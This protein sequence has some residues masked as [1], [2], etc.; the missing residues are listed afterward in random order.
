MHSIKICKFTR[1]KKIFYSFKH[2]ICIHLTNFFSITNSTVN[3]RQRYIFSRTRPISYLKWFSTCIW[4]SPA[5]GQSS[6]APSSRARPCC[7]PFWNL[8]KLHLTL[9]VVAFVVVVAQF[10]GH[11]LIR[12]QLRSFRNLAP[13]KF[14]QLSLASGWASIFRTHMCH[15]AIPN[16]IPSWQIVIV[17]GGPHLQAI[18]LVFSLHHLTRAFFFHFRP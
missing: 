15:I 7:C 11:I 6:P 4:S 1:K 13:L 12:W 2:F 5:G 10:Q 17:T 9:V 8:S 14:Q 16:F 18:R 3:E